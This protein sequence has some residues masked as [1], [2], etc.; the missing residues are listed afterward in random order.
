MGSNHGSK[1]GEL[2]KP[3]VNPPLIWTPEPLLYCYRCPVHRTMQ[4]LGYYYLGQQFENHRTDML[5]PPVPFKLAIVAPWLLGR[6]GEGK[7]ERALLPAAF[8]G[9]TEIPQ[10]GHVGE[11]WCFKLGASERRT[12]GKCLGLGQLKIKLSFSQ[13]QGA[14][15]NIITEPKGCFL[16]L[17]H[18]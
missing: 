13:G 14:E 15:K 11:V 10:P 9:T 6:E 3:C 16:P 18:F 7:E 5:F 8:P 17:S 2:G 1:F 4:H 12:K